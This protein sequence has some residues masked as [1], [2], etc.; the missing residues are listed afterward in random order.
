MFDDKGKTVD[1]SRAVDAGRRS[2]ACNEV[3]VAGDTLPVVKD[4]RAARAD[5]EDA[6]ARA[7]GRDSCR[8]GA[9]GQPGHALRRD[10]RR[11]DARS[12]TSSSRRT[13]R[14]RIDPIRHSLERLSNEE[15]KREDHPLRLR[16]DHGVGRDARRGIQ[17]HHHRL[18]R[19]DRRRAPRSSPTRRRSRSASTAS[20]TT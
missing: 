2:W 3:P 19:E 10:Q 18:Q 7:R 15:V 11:Q 5:I 4:E 8:E 9:P 17:G 13:C 14:A 12:S 1:R 20:S 6:Q 16:R